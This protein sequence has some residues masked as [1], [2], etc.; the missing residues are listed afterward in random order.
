[1]RFLLS[2]TAALWLAGCP[3][4]GPCCTTKD[5]PG[6][7]V[8][9]VTDCTQN[10]RVGGNCTSRCQV[11]YDCNDPNLFCNAVVPPGSAPSSDVGVVCG[12]GPRGADASCG[13][14]AGCLGH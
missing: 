3:A 6:G 11:D 13:S 10:A 5:C 9:T 1:V 8:C 7:N 14:C 12:C 2:L 4:D